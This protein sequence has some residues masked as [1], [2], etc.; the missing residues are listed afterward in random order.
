MLFQKL[1]QQDHYL[2]QQKKGLE[3]I[4]KKSN[5]LDY[6]K[7]KAYRIITLLICL[8]KVSEKIIANRLVY[9]ASLIDKNS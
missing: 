9:Y 8:E 4:L 3:A 2:I 7:F 1:I 6:S 5:K